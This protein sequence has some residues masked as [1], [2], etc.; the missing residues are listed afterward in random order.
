[1]HNKRI[2][3]SQIVNM[4]FLV[5]RELVLKCGFPE[6]ARTSV[7]A[8]ISTW[9]A[10]TLTVMVTAMKPK[11]AVMQ[12]DDLMTHA[13]RYATFLMR[14]NGRLPPTVLASTPKGGVCYVPHDLADARAKDNFANAARLIC[15]AYAATAV[16]MALEAWVTTAKPG[17]PLDDTP[18]SE[19]FDRREFVILMGEAAGQ[20]KQKM[21]P[22]IRTDAGGFF[23]FGEFDTSSY[24]DF[25]GRFV[26]LLPPKVPTTEQRALAKAML[27]MM[28]V[29]DATLGR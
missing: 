10:P 27:E 3:P 24:T 5:G 17:E 25:Q 8:H 28:G 21:L 22:I 16:V 12:L 19:A 4:V 15:A 29:T 18:P 2:A 11:P 9:L 23:G 1:M 14:K 26:G 6:A 7:T 20:K 13:E